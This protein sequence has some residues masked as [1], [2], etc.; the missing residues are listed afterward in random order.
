MIGVGVT[1]RTLRSN[2]SN[3][4]TNFEQKRS[5][6]WKRLS[7]LEDEVH[8]LYLNKASNGVVL[9]NIN[10]NLEEIDGSIKELKDGKRSK[11]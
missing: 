10:N 2:I 4:E 1:W 6:V 8:A 9:K 11:K 7:K 3:M 5:V